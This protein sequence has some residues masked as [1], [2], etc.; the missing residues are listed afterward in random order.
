MYNYLFE[1]N[2]IFSLNRIEELP[3]QIFV[4]CTDLLYLNLANNRLE[5]FPPQIRRLVQLHTLIL[6]NNPLTHFQFR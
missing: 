4:N 2:H 1:I 6:N 3:A 5:T